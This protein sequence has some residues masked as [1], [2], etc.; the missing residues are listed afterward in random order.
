MSR[1]FCVKYN[2]LDTNQLISGGWDDTVHIWD[3]RIQHS[4]RYL[5]FKFYLFLQII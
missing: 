2:P 5:I 4:Q 3:D 1:V